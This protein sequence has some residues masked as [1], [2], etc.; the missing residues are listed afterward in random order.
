M[1]AWHDRESC[2]AG[3]DAD[4]SSRQASATKT[5]RGTHQTRIMGDT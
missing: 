4:D 3:A 5:G 1:Q 2:D